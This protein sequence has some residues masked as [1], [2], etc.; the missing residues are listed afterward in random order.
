[1]DDESHTGKL[2]TKAMQNEKAKPPKRTFIKQKLN[3][4]MKRKRTEINE[5]AIQRSDPLQ[6][7]ICTT[8]R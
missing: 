7:M 3:S 2:H 5:N 8:T 1:M 6:K 4:S